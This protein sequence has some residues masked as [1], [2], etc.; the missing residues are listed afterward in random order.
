MSDRPFTAENLDFYLRELAKAYKKLGGKQTPAEIILIGGAA[1][2][3]NYG[4]REMTYDMDAIIAA[5]SA[6]DDAIRQVGDACG[7]PAGW[8]N[9]DFRRTKS[10]TPKLIEYSKYYK[11]FSGVLTVRT[12][13]AEYLIAMK[14][15]S[16]RQYKNDLSDIVGI[17][18]EHQRRGAPLSFQQIDR[19]IR[20]LYG[21]WEGIDADTRQLL[22]RVL[23]LPDAFAVYAE[24]RDAEAAAQRLLLDFESRYPRVLRESNLKD[25]LAQAKKKK[26]QSEDQN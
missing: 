25:I 7:L 14:L 21:S 16:A 26:Q 19:A 20:E 9:T 2:L 17:V 6:M 18:G 5:S 22:E 24:Y 3:A 12:V 23:Q 1:I 4:F 13:T 15:V 10:Y 8:L 11:T